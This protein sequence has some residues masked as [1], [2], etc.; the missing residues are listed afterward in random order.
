MRA[1]VVAAAIVLSSAPAAAQPVPYSSGGEAQTQL[2]P[3]GGP[4]PMLP[5]TPRR[6]PRGYHLERTFQPVYVASGA[7]LFAFSYLLAVVLARAGSEPAILANDEQLTR[8][9]A[10]NRPLYAPVVGPIIALS[11][12][13]RTGAQRAILGLDAAGQLAGL[14]LF[15]AGLAIR[16]KRVVPDYGRIAPV[17]APGYLGLHGAF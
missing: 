5:G 11:Q 13:D 1:L 7:S 12:S 4:E 15:A 8:N 17:I 2:H 9:P 14:G 3:Y 6:K 16:E 10:L